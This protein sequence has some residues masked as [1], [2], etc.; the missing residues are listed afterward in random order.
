MEERRPACAP[1]GVGAVRERAGAIDARP[2]SANGSGSRAP[3]R[4]SALKSLMHSHSIDV[5]LVLV[6]KSMALRGEVTQ[7]RLKGGMPLG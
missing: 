5:Q 1:Y 3:S 7:E 4:L 2:E 6:G